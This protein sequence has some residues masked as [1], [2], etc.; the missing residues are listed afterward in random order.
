M[1]DWRDIEIHDQAQCCCCSHGHIRCAVFLS[2]DF[3]D[4]APVCHDCLTAVQRAL[5]HTG[6]MDELPAP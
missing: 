4:E 5:D 6:G 1:A 3:A 2:G